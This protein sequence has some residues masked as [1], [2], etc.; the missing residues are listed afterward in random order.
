METNKNGESK[1]QASLII[2][3]LENLR[4]LNLS[5]SEFGGIVP[6]QLGTLS[7]LHVLCHGSFYKQLESTGMI[8]VIT[9]ELT[10]MSNMH[11]LSSLRML[12]HL[13]LSGVDLSK[14]NR[15]ASSD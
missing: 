6:A 13:D 4:Y 8:S 2:S 1:F 5:K 12:H 14:A 7:E 11:W 10:R 15:L 3:S 9:I